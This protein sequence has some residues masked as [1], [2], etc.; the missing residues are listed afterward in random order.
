MKINLLMC[1]N[2]KVFD[3]MLIELLS[4]VKHNK[5]EITLYLMT[6]DLT[7]ISPRF[8]AVS[9]K[10]RKYLED[11]LKQGNKNSKII[12]LDM[13]EPFLKEMKD[14]PNMMNF[15]TPYTMLRLFAD[16]LPK[17]VDKIL[18]LD[19]DLGILGDIAPLYNIDLS[20]Y[21]FGAAYD[22]LGRYFIGNYYQNAGVI[23]FNID[24]CR[25]TKF[26]EN[27]RYKCLH[28]KMAFLDQDAINRTVKERYFIPYIYNVQRNMKKGTVIKHFCKTIRW[29][30]FYH[31]SN[32]KPWNVEGVHKTLKLHCF[33][34]VLLDYQNR[35][36]E[37]RK[38]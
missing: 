30:P 35:I 32:I 15:Y 13:R 6:M 16:F 9:E 29:L 3:G 25:E 20:G 4:L 14:S 33:D 34:D 27:C 2:D 19:C 38:K 12:L 7:D 26:F 28:D 18:Y 36:K 1:G 37:Y 22:V 17:E 31:T 5:H 21:E 10:D 11:V 23:L 24:K 8:V